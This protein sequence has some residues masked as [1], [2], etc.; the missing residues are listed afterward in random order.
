MNLTAPK[1][2]HCPAMSEVQRVGRPK[3]APSVPLDD[4]GSECGCVPPWERVMLCKKK[5]KFTAGGLIEQR[6][7]EAVGSI[8]DVDHEPLHFVV[9]EARDVVPRNDAVWTAD[10]DIR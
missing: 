8:D 9:V 10:R 7:Y 1:R 5:Q 3:F 4:C 6:V 2:R